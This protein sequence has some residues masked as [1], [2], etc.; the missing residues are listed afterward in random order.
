MSKEARREIEKDEEKL[1]DIVSDMYVLCKRIAYFAGLVI[2]GL[3]ILIII[4]AIIKPK[5]A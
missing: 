3:I 5:S 2:I 4:L 1:D